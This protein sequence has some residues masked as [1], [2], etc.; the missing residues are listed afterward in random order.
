M[1]RRS[2]EAFMKLTLHTHIHPFK[3]I[4]YISSFVSMAARHVDQMAN[5][6]LQ[7]QVSLIM[8]IMKLI[9]TPNATATMGIVEIDANMITD[10][11]GRAR[12]RSG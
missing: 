6:D 2:V 11:S 8:K 10:L 5:V 7:D 9:T 12:L 4:I 1:C 3:I